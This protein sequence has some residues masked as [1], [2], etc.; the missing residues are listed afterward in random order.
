MTRWLLGLALLGSAGCMGMDDHYVYD[1]GYGWVVSGDCPCNAPAGGIAYQP[2]AYPSRAHPSPIQQAGL[3][4][5]PT[6]NSG[7]VPAGG[8]MPPQTKEPPR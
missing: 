2:T 1:D 7:V 3:T 4:T 8:F 6:G 5:T